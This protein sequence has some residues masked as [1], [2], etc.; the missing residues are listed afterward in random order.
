MSNDTRLTTT[1]DIEQ[2]VQLVDSDWTLHEETPE[3]S[4]RHFTHRLRVD[5][6]SGEK[7][8]ILKASEDEDSFCHEAR[9]LSVLDEATD[10]PVA[11]VHGVVDEHGDL[12]TPFF[13]MEELPGESIHKSETDTLSKRTLRQIAVSSG[14]QLAMLHDLDA[15]D[16][17][18]AVSIEEGE[19]LLGGIPT[20]DPETLYVADGDASWATH[21]E[22]SFDRIL[23]ALTDSRF[24]DVHSNVEAVAGSMVDALRADDSFDPVVGRVEH[25]MDNIL[26]DLDAGEVTGMLDWEF[27]ASMTPANDL[28]YAEFWLSGGQWSLLP[29]TTDYRDLIREGLL[30]GY[31]SR[32]AATVLDEYRTHRDCYETIQLL[33]TMVHFEGMFEAYGA[34]DRQRSEA[35][36][37]LQERLSEVMQ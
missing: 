20:S 4:G 36:S 29:S 12:P 23:D 18:G 33:R 25:S 14:R 17:F 6:A 19:P 1:A 9:L 37:V 13:I 5:T 15:V 22:A 27:V 10:L 34:T 11:S 30:E 8:V 21:V 16:E 35:A 31:R 28:V 3:S 32:G 2:M 7:R 26:V 24:D